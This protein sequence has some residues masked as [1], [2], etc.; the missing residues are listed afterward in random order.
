MPARIGSLIDKRDNF[1]IIRDQ[2]AAILVVES[3]NQQALAASAVPEKDPRLWKL[4]VFTERSNAWEEWLEAPSEQLDHAPIVNVSFETDSVDGAAS[5]VV[6]RQKMNGVFHI[7][8]YGYG[9]ASAD[10]DGHKPGDQEAA[11]VAQRAVRLV[12]NILMAEAYVFLGLP[13]GP[14]QFVAKRMVQSRTMSQLPLD[15]A[16]VQQIS[17]CRLAL[18]VDFNEFSP[19]IETEILEFISVTVRRAETGEVL[20]K[21]KYEPEDS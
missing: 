13:R 20:L 11:L 3:E 2:I 1:E 19:Q 4:R 14:N 17:A 9:V 6:N 7:D 5:T 18:Q 15:N 12:R 10:G 16:S 8:C 21:A